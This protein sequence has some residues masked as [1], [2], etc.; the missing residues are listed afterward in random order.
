MA[1]KKSPAELDREIAAALAATSG[2]PFGDRRRLRAVSRSVQHEKR[3]EIEAL[4]PLGSIVKVTKGSPE[5]V[6]KVGRVTGYDLG[7]DEDA[8]LVLVRYGT[9]AKVG[10]Y[11][12]RGGK[13]HEDEVVRV[14]RAEG[15]VSHARRSGWTVV[16]EDGYVKVKRDGETIAAGVDTGGKRLSGVEFTHDEYQR[17]NPTRQKAMQVLQAKGYR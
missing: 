3:K 17:S 5:F 2:A 13:Y 6:G 12:I 7:M 9:I 14:P 16:V 11:R 1:R 15:V 4:F 8:A 10:P